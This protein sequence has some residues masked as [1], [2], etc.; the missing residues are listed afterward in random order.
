[1]RERKMGDILKALVLAMFVLALIVNVYA[2]DY[3]SSYT[4]S[5]FNSQNQYYQPNF[6]SIYPVKEGFVDYKTLWPMV[7]NQENCN[8]SRQDFIVSVRPGGCSPA[9]VRS[10]LL[11]EQNVPVFC[12]LDAIKLNPLIDVA[13]VKSVTFKGDYASAGVA[14]VSFHPSLAAL[15]LYNKVLDSALV[16]DIGYVV[17]VLKQAGNE[18]EMKNSVLVNLTA[19]LHYDIER[20]FGSGNSNYYLPLLDDIE[21][22]NNYK[23]YGFWKGRGYLRV[24]E[25]E[26]DKAVINIYNDEDSILRK[27]TLKKGETSG[28]IYI[29]GFYCNAGISLKLK[30]L[31]SGKNRARLTIDGNDVWV[32]QGEKILDGECSVT[33]IKSSGLISEVVLRCKGKD[34]VLK[35]SLSDRVRFVKG[36]NKNDV[37]LGAKLD[38][39]YLIYIGKK[40]SENKIFAIMASGVKELFLNI[41]KTKVSDA[42]LKEVMDRYE[43]WSKGCQSQKSGDKEKECIQ[44]NIKSYFSDEK[45]KVEI[46]NEDEKETGGYSLEVYKPEDKKLEEDIKTNF[47]GAIKSADELVKI[48]GNEKKETG[49]YYGAEA[50]FELA[51]LAEKLEQNNVKKSA[52]ENLTRSYPSSPL[53]REAE[54]KLGKMNLYNYEYA[55]SLITINQETHFIVLDS[56]VKPGFD[57]SSAEFSVTKDG[58]EPKTESFLLD[59]Y[60]L[61][62]ATKDRVQ[63]VK[64]KGISDD[65]IDVEFRHL[66]SVSSGSVT[67]PSTSEQI[68][69]EQKKMK[70]G[71]AIIID[72][73]NKVILNK[74]S[75]K[76]V[77]EIE[78][79]SKIPKTESEA[80]FSVKIGIEKR[81]IKLS[82]DKTLERIKNINE[83]IEKWDKITS[84]LGNVVSAM[85]GVCFA[86]SATLIVKNM[87][88]NL[89]GR[90]SAR[91]IAMRSRGGWVEQCNKEMAESKGKYASLDAC[92]YANKDKIDADVTRIETEIKRTNSEIVSINKQHEVSSGMFGKDVNGKA[93]GAD[94]AQNVFAPY[95]KAHKNEKIS[96]SDGSEV[97]LG[98]I[99]SKDGTSDAEIDKNINDMYGKGQ[100]SLQEMRDSVTYGR[101]AS[102]AGANTLDYNVAQSRLSPILAPLKET[103]ESENQKAAFAGLVGK[104]GGVFTPSQ[105]GLSPKIVNIVKLDGDKMG[106]I[107][108][109]DKF[110]TDDEVIPMVIPSIG[111]GLDKTGLAGKKILAK[112]K[113]MSGNNQYNLDF[114]TDG[115]AGKIYFVGEDGKVGNKLEVT[116]Q[117]SLRKYLET[118]GVSYFQKWK[119]ED[120]ANTYSSPEVKFYEFEPYKGMPAVVPIDTKKGWYAATKQISTSF[121]GTKPFA[122]SGAV[123]SLWI[124]NV[125]KN[126]REEWQSG[127]SDDGPCTEYNYNTGQPN[128]QIPCLSEAEA[129]RYVNAA[130]YLM[131][132]AAS[133]YGNG[134]RE[135]VLDALSG[136]QRFPVKP[137]LKIPQ[138]QCEDFMSPEDCHVLFN[139]CDPVICPS[140]RCDFGGRYPVDDVI[141]SGIIGSLA[142]CMPNFVGFGGDVYLPVCLSGI[143]AGLQSYI[144]ILKSHRDCLQESVN[145][146]KY[147]GICDEIYSIYLCEFFWRQAAPLMDIAIPKLIE[148][149]Y[150][151]GQGQARGGGEYMTVQDSWDNAQ[152]S[153]QYMTSYYG[154]NAFKAFQMRSSAEIGSDVCKAFI[155]TRYP[156][157]FN[158]LLEPDSPFQFYAKFDEIPLNDATVPA[159]SQY[160]VYY[161]IFAGEDSGNYFSVYLKNPPQTGYYATQPYIVV[162]SG[163]IGAGQTIDKAPDFS[164]P[165]GY[166]ELCVRIGTKDEC[167]FKQV[168]T[169]FAVNYIRDSYA[170]SEAVG[171]VIA[172]EK[173][174]VSGTPNAMGLINPNI[175]EGIQDAV[176]P[177]IS[178]QGIVR[179][180]S[181]KNPG[182][183]KSPRWKDVGNCDITKNV[184]CWLDTESVSKSIKDLGLEKQTLTEATQ[185]MNEIENSGLLTE[186]ETSS[187]LKEV[188]KKIEAKSFEGSKLGEELKVLK[189]KGFFSNQKARAY[190]FE[191][192]MFKILSENS[193]A[194][195]AKTLTAQVGGSNTATA[196]ESGATTTGVGG[197]KET[198]CKSEDIEQSDTYFYSYPTALNR[199][200]EIIS[201]NTNIQ[202]INYVQNE[203]FKKF[204]NKLFCQQSPVLGSKQYLEIVRNN[205]NILTLKNLILSLMETK[206]NSDFV[207]YCI[208]NQIYM[209]NSDA[210]QKSLLTGVL[211][212]AEDSSSIT[213][214]INDLDFSKFNYVYLDIA[215]QQQSICDDSITT[216]SFTNEDNKIIGTFSSQIAKNSYYY[217]LIDISNI[218]NSL[219]INEVYFIESFIQKGSQQTSISKRKI[220]II[221]K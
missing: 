98:K 99:F 109:S 41:E 86:T 21:W 181:T 50:L 92:F 205:E 87:F 74:I 149:A 143:Y 77:A 146:G 157:A 24:E 62:T 2:V 43:I 31:T 219:N 66:S 199:I 57:E 64:L 161:H 107:G 160:K 53:S 214:P 67:S 164:A 97:E 198:L 34:I 15:R 116:E 159:T 108:G 47:D 36:E 217:G 174:C 188:Q 120:C 20:I 37:V 42:G 195:G 54:L 22:K 56:V 79:I 7:L 132:Q 44:N 178:S 113:L 137:A 33:S 73:K 38:S 180:C 70:V 84:K 191:F 58:K 55:T 156:N 29:P 197:D 204:V 12:K 183:D 17:V 94:Y 106:A 168:S 192:K 193:L 209:S 10:D 221:K 45:G 150:T 76:R 139:V 49:E 203:E 186:K 23:S 170:K 52:L 68:I 125:G 19:T 138:T 196:S 189:E 101:V 155:S 185:K 135:I 184:K 60:V 163:Y 40:K 162:D 117:E 169:S 93:A 83:S 119:P 130:K 35:I 145:T 158:N 13:A 182:G 46:V 131:E 61:Y 166:K 85:K 27:V 129:K 123:N 179:V 172:S 152:K 100:L 82:P 210:S 91:Q 122:S 112:A 171:N 220:K 32:L 4:S 88:Q 215:S 144:S 127:A 167:G 75:L 96:M 8:G 133:Q 201:K 151:G 69:T 153:V 218:Q 114:P 105:K 136:Q 14:G 212:T 5:K 80:N 154:P 207:S 63:Y 103:R 89:G 6:E 71:E 141:Q 148:Y 39:S 16:N 110:G 81:A 124:C 208:I 26:K 72:A 18:K 194:G 1:M 206:G 176:Q 190:F 173:E 126:G 200:N 121:S 115:K 165:A 177:E 118:S 128:D 59:D 90:S 48:Y 140:S 28:V 102:G 11:E 111:K 30:D 175:Q 78:L 9:V 95:V 51:E 216:I 65:E 134:K 202:E 147:I 187:R 211:I 3:T 213:Y 142:L 25:T 104:D